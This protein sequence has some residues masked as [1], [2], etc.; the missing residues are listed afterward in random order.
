MTP[1]MS[2]IPLASKRS[3]RRPVRGLTNTI[4]KKAAELAQYQGSL[5]G[6]SLNDQQLTRLGLSPGRTWGVDP[7]SFLSA[8]NDATSGSAASREEQAQEAALSQLAGVD[9][10]YLPDT[11]T[12]G[13]YDPSKNLS[14]DTGR[15]TSAVD[16]ARAGIEPQ[17]QK[18]DYATGIAN[19]AGSLAGVSGD[20]KFLMS[21]WNEDSGNKVAPLLQ[22]EGIDYRTARGQYASPLQFA[23][24]MQSK[25][26][27]QAQQASSYIPANYLAEL[28]RA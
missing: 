24:A 3:S 4:S 11:A 28:K 25:Y 9:N 14:Y 8:Q 19:T 13:S 27:S 21:T 1:G 17:V 22:A 16:A 26:G 23:Q 10:T 18:R 2:W 6:L 7:T 15:Y 5:K 20:D 12:A